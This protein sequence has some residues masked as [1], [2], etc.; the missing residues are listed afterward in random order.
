MEVNNGKVDGRRR[1]GGRECGLV[2]KWRRREVVLRGGGGVSGRKKETRE[3]E[4]DSK[5]V[6]W[7]RIISG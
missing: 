1:L 2:E 4:K 5:R 6:E 7:K 3:A